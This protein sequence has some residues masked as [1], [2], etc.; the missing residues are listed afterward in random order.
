MTKLRRILLKQ[1]KL[2]TFMFLVCLTTLSM[3]QML[4]MPNAC[5]I[6]RNELRR[7]HNSLRYY[8]PN[9]SSNEV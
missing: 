6:L 2:T 7:I 8:K 9:L 4:I 5:I 1:V 3:T